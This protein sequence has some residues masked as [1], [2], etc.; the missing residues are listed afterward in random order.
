MSVLGEL[1]A[2]DL[3]SELYENL[4]K[5]SLS[6]YSRKKTGSLITRVTCEEISI[7]SPIRRT[8]T[9]RHAHFSGRTWIDVGLSEGGRRGR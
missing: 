6:F 3:R 9:S 5:L 2:R 4:Q 1:V 8:R 7:F